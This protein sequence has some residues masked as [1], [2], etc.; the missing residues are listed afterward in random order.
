MRSIDT[1]K[2]EIRTFF[3]CLYIYP[4]HDFT[5][6]PIPEHHE[7]LSPRNKNRTTIQRINRG[8]GVVVATELVVAVVVAHACYGDGRGDGVVVVTVVDVR[9]ILLIGQ[10]TLDW[11]RCPSPGHLAQLVA[12]TLRILTA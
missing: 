10:S 9:G 3:F 6:L 8:S 7:P 11:S 12:R 1:E 4:S 5:R 2:G